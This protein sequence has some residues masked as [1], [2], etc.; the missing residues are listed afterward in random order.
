MANKK[1]LVIVESSSKAKT[2]NKYLGKDF[3]V[4]ASNGHIKDIVKNTL[5][6][7]VKNGFTIKYASD[8][9][10]AELIKKLKNDASNAKNVL[11]ATDPDREGEAIAWHIATE[12]K[13]NNDDIKRVTFTEITKNNILK[14]IANPRSIDMQMVHSQQARRVMDRLIGFKISSF[15]SNALVK[16]VTTNALSAGRVQSVA[17]RFI[18]EREAEIQMF[19]PIE[20][21]K[22]NSDFA[23]IKN[24]IFSAELIEFDGKKIVK[25]EGSM[26]AHTEEEK[27]KIEEKLNKQHYIK[28]KEQAEDLLNRIKNS[29]F[30][31]SKIKKEQ[32]T[33]RPKPPFTTSQLQQD[34]SR[35]L[36]MKNADTMKIAQELYEG[37]DLGGTLGHVGLIT[38]M[39]TDSVRISDDAVAACRDYIKDKYGNDYL[40]KIPNVYKSKSTNVQDAHEAIRPTSME[41]TPE[42]IEKN[43][44]ASADRKRKLVKLYKLIYNRFLASQM[45]NAL[46]ES[47]TV[48]IKSAGDDF[49]FKSSGSIIKFNGFLA[50]YGNEEE[51]E[52]RLPV[53]LEENQ[54]VTI[55]KLDKSLTQTKP[56]ARYNPASLVA[57]L[58]EK[59]IGRP[60]TYATIIQTL[61]TKKYIVEV[62]KAFVPTELGISLNSV[63]VENF[64]SLFNDKFTS[65]M[66]QDLDEIAEGN[67]TYLDLLN[68]FYKPFSESLQEAIN[69]QSSSDNAIKC[70]VCGGNMVIKVSRKGR[71][72]GCSNYPECK[73]TKPLPSSAK[74]EKHE[75]VIA[76]G[77]VCPNCG[78][79]M[80]IRES[81]Y[82]KFYGCSNYPKCKG[83]LPIKSDIVCPECGKGTL[84][85]RYSAKTKKRFW[86]CSNYPECNYL[87][88]NEPVKHTCPEC[89]SE[90]MEIKY[91]KVEDGFEK[92]LNCPKCKNKLDLED[93]K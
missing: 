16:N 3:L 37:V 87:T 60:S 55:N 11:I 42:F 34:A 83:I 45:E 23:T 14:N 65:D 28:T 38:Y 47:T 54:T 53:G 89:H 64:D 86:G 43:I 51:K 10:K 90:Y 27:K 19:T 73:N 41:Y 77:I 70:D 48:T 78:S 76:E 26:T 46:K 93:N 81:R 44:V 91:R 36:G 20:Y 56:N 57:E 66:E 80:Y 50:V 72:L 35:K 29:E 15:A 79:P 21:W 75:P 6:V 69:K 85:E 33:E 74:E 1:T 2:I 8:R 18:C 22:I 39:R 31:I 17:L 59:G 40:P 25:P 61:L 24:D 7:D 63:L 13:D 4:E 5:G 62:N 9:S 52:S 32:K 68:K 82:G 88:N 92:Y 71:F 49:V 30:S 67:T 12:L 58:D 84:I